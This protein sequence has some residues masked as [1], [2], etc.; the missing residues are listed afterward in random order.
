MYGDHKANEILRLC[1]HKAVLRLDS[2]ITAQWAS[3]LFG[4]V[5]ELET[6]VSSSDGTSNTI[7][8]IKSQSQQGTQT[9][10][11]QVL[12]EVVLA[13]EFLWIPFPSE[14][15]GMRGYYLS[16]ELGGVGYGAW[17]RGDSISNSLRPI[18]AVEGIIRR[19]D[20]HQYMGHGQLNAQ[21]PLVLAR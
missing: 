18:G 2:A 19:P 1:G 17:I 3:D 4:K 11:R 16:P 21:K 13:S 7:M 15:N 6:S 5:E 14:A 20:E 8:S 12:R 10:Q 9:T